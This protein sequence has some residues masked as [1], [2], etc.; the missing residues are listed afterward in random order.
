MKKR[1]GIITVYNSVNSGSYLQAMA[2]CKTIESNGNEVFFYDSKTRKPRKKAFKTGLWHII[3]GGGLKMSIEPIKQ[4]RKFN[5]LVKKMNIER[6]IEAS[7]IIVLG[8]DEIWNVSRSTMSDYPI[9]W[10]DGLTNDII[11]YAPSIN[12]SKVT[13]LDNFTYV[14]PALKKMKLITVR[15]EHSKQVLQSIVDLEMKIVVDPTIF[16]TKEEYITLAKR[17]EQTNFLFVYS[18]GGEFSE[19]E[20]HE[21]KA[22]A[23]KRELKIIGAPYMA[24]VDENVFPDP[25]E[26]LG[27]LE[28]AD[29]VV[30]GTFHG[31]IFSIIFNKKFISIMRN[32]RKVEEVLNNFSLSSRGLENN[33]LEEL[34]DSSIDYKIVN[35]LIE[36]KRKESLEILYNGINN[37]EE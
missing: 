26:F 18:R 34:L 22:F 14:I 10:G 6:K 21:I 8:S 29:Y 20:I 13:D 12:N 30:T 27:Y 11:S 32:N 17:P 31:T 25:L 28:A 15:D 2:L 3:R 23:E 16:S 36:T 37:I 19:N 7:D 1:I 33:N 5:R 4:Y 9:F 35:Q 24:W